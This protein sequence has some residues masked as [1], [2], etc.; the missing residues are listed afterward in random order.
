[1]ATLYIADMLASRPAAAE[2]AQAE[3][4]P[5]AVIWEF[6]DKSTD[7]WR[8]KVSFCYGIIF[9][10]VSRFKKWYAIGSKNKVCL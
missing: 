3:P 2:T 1:M 4:D 7:E 10:E 5:R 6:L 8:V 9:A